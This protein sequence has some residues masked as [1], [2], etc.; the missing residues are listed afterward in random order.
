MK[1]NNIEQRYIFLIKIK[2]ISILNI[3]FF[4]REKTFSE[5]KN[6]LKIIL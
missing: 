4:I 6:V 1:L 2:I 5:Q 3:L